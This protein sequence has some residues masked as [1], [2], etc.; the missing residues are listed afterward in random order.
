MSIPMSKKTLFASEQEGEAILSRLAAHSGSS[1][2]SSSPP[3][4]ANSESV[5]SSKH[6]DIDTLKK[7]LEAAKTK[8][9]QLSMGFMDS[10]VDDPLLATKRKEL[11]LAQEKVAILVK[12]IE[13]QE[14]TSFDKTIRDVKLITQAPVFQLANMVKCDKTLPI[15]DDI[16]MFV[17]RFDKVMITH[18]VDRDHYWKANLA[19]SIQDHTVDQWF[20]G[21]LANK[22]C[23]WNEART[24]L[25]DKFEDKPSNM[26]TATNLFTIKMERSETL[27]AFSLRFLATMRDAKWED[28][29]SMAMLYLHALHKS[30]GNDMMVAYNSKEQAHSR[31]QSV[32]DVFRLAGKLYQNKRSLENDSQDS[33]VFKTRKRSRKRSRH[34]SYYC[35]RHGANSGHPSSECRT[36]RISDPPSRRGYKRAPTHSNSYNNSSSNNDT[37]QQLALPNTVDTFGSQSTDLPLS[38]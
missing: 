28:G 26:M 6:A 2:T 9:N 18:Q 30:L 4:M 11:A 36:L 24:I 25:I 38:R 31:P 13:W 37:I 10:Q 35:T 33:P 20:S 22:D 8:A 32:D 15:F 29:P 5:N 27:P 34:S 1:L 23:T 21:A 3:D 14:D 16:H 19:A 7:T 17:N 12:N